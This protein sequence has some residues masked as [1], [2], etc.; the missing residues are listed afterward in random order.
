MKDGISNLLLLQQEE[1]EM[2]VPN[3]QSSVQQAIRMNTH[4]QSL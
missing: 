2:T 3:P 1:V 4:G